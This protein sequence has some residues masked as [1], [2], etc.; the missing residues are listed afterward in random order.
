MRRIDTINFIGMPVEIFEMVIF[1]FST[2]PQLTIE[3]LHIKRTD[4]TTVKNR[5]TNAI[6]LMIMARMCNSCTSQLHHSDTPTA[7]PVMI[8]RQM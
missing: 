2:T 1:V 7:P 8:Q 3:R 6:V 5:K 4:G